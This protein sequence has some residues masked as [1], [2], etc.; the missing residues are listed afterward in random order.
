MTAMHCACFNVFITQ[1]EN[2]YGIYKIH[3]EIYSTVI[4]PLQLIQ[5]GHLLVS[6]KRMCTQVL[7]KGQSAV[8][9]TVT[10]VGVVTWKLMGSSRSGQLPDVNK[11]FTCGNQLIHSANPTFS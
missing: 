9:P 10:V 7:L 2:I 3:H 1:D 5:E 4:L 6:G 8:G 11:T